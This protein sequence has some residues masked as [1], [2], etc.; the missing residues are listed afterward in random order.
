MD[1]SAEIAY[2]PRET[3]PQHQ[4]EFGAWVSVGEDWKQKTEQ[5]NCNMQSETD[6]EANRGKEL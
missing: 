4:I 3:A 5:K 6:I 1:I 2:V